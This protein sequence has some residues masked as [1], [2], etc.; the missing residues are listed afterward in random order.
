MQALVRAHYR[1]LCE[2]FFSFRDSKFVLDFNYVVQKQEK[3][4]ICFG[5]GQERRK[6]VPVSRHEVKNLK[7]Y[8]ENYQPGKYTLPPEMLAPRPVSKKGTVL[9]GRTAVRCF[10]PRLIQCP[11]PCTYEIKSPK[12]LK[13]GF[14]SRTERFRKSTKKV[15]VG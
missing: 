7:E 4:E 10:S 6:I 2:T 9:G 1:P 13:E 12:V 15:I 11:S 3:S 5:S 8:N 14:V